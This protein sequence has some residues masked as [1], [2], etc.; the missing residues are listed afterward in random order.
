MLIFYTSNHLLDA[1]VFLSMRSLSVE[2][3]ASHWIFVPPLN[4]IHRLKPN[5]WWD[6]IWRWG[7]AQ[8]IKSWGWNTSGWLSVLIKRPR[9][10]L[11]SFYH[12]STE[13]EVGPHHKPINH[14]GTEFEL[15]TSQFVKIT[16]LSFIN[17]WVC[18]SSL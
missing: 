14:T 17:H 4:K 18:S 9:H 5:P 8:V 3:I 16:F 12:V 11:C 1:F 13:Q 6:S 10:H 2:S 7:F 15:S